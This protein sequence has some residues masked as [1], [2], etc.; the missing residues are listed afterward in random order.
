MESLHDPKLDASAVLMQEYVFGM[1]LLV[2]FL[3]LG[4]DIVSVV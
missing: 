4:W 2:F 3:L 1:T